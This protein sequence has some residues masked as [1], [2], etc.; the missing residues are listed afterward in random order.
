MNLSS[1][2]RPGLAVALLSALPPVAA[3]SEEALRKRF[4]GTHVTV[5]LDMPGDVS[6]IDLYPGTGQPVDFRRIG[7]R[8]R[9]Y[10]VAIRRGDSVMVTQVKVKPKLIEFQLAG[11]GYGTWGDK[12]SEPSTGSGRTQ[13]QARMTKAQ[14]VA[15]RRRASGSRF[16]IHYEA[17][18]SAELATPER[19]ISVLSEFVEFGDEE[20]L[21]AGARARQK[22]LETRLATEGANSVPALRKGMTEA[23]V[24]TLCGEPASRKAAKTGDM[25]QV[26]A[27]YDLPGHTVSARF[28]SGV[29]VKYAIAAK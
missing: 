13:A 27:E 15:D 9:L 21:G 14:I 5:K 11:G 17:G 10:G 1:T 8:I 23:E 24:N 7:S 20:P 29:L 28:V 16:N 25:E 18:V 12:F 4:E 2:L 22:T 3:Q 6:G 26:D 19:I